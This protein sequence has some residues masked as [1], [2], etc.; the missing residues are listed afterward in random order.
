[1]T[2]S[3][4]QIKIDCPRVIDL[5]KEASRLKN[6]NNLKE[7]LIR[8]GKEIPHG[9]GRKDELIKFISELEF[10][11]E[12]SQSEQPKPEP[13]PVEEMESTPTTHHLHRW[14]CLCFR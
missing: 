4:A 10:L 7:P 6:A 5:R 1:M 13:E 2:R 8:D 11:V 12:T 14:F 9:K 3:I